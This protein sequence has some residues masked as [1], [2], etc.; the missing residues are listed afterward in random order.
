MWG[1][2]AGA[3]KAQLPEGLPALLGGPQALFNV[4]GGGKGEGVQ[5]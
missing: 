5:V 4:T 1:D 3:V 2:K